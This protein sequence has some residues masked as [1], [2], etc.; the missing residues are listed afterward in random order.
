MGCTSLRYMNAKNK[1]C[2]IIFQNSTCFGAE[3][4]CYLLCKYCSC[5]NYLDVLQCIIESLLWAL[6]VNIVFIHFYTKASPQV[7]PVTAFYHQLILKSSFR[8]F[9]VLT[10]IHVLLP[11]VF[12]VFSYQRFKNPGRKVLNTMYR[13]SEKL[14]FLL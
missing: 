13:Y 10:Y 6:C 4:C 5:M 11:R 14:L 1:I 3:Y 2:S 9:H 7:I 8:G 12:Q